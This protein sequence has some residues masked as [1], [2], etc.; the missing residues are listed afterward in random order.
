MVANRKFSLHGGHTFRASWIQNQNTTLEDDELWRSSQTQQP[1]Y[2]LL[3]RQVAPATFI[4]FATFVLCYRGKL[5]R[6]PFLLH[7]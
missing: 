5:P 7:E 2:Y 6:Y 4:L 1:F 3:S